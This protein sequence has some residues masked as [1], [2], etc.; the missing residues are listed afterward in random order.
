MQLAIK[1]VKYGKNASDRLQMSV[2]VF[3]L[4]GWPIAAE[5]NA[6]GVAC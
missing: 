2:R 4:K 1:Q 6:L 5:G 3:S